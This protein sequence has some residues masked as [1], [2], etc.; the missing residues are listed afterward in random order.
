MKQMLSVGT[1]IIGQVTQRY[2]RRSI[3]GTESSVQS[4]K[5]LTQFW[6]TRQRATMRP[7]Q[8]NE[9]HIAQVQE[10]HEAMSEARQTKD[11]A[12]DAWMKLDSQTPL[13]Q[14][15]FVKAESQKNDAVYRHDVAK[16]IHKVYH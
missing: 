11:Q 6:K 12:V 16:A 14:D 7:R 1:P 2:C 8:K 9:K 10:A 15:N 4:I 5:L 3:I 13:L